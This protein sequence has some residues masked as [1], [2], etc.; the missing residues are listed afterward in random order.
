MKFKTKK[1][2]FKPKVKLITLALLFFLQP[3]ITFA[4]TD[5]GVSFFPNKSIGFIGLLTGL[6]IIAVVLVLFLV[7]KLSSNTNHH[8]HEKSLLKKEKFKKYINNLNQS[9][10]EVLKKKEAKTITEFQ[11]WYLVYYHSYHK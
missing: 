5:E 6:V 10:I 9:E 1:L 3:I 8:L 4:Q 2:F 11:F 7:V